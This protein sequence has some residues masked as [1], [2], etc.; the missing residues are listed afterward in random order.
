M[1]GALETFVPQAVTKGQVDYEMVGVLLN[2]GKI[3]ILLSFI[4]MTVFFLFTEKLL[5]LANQ[6]P[7]VARYAQLY[8]FVSLP[9]LLLFGLFDCLRRWLNSL[10]YSKVPLLCQMVAVPLHVVWSYVFVIH[11][12]MEYYGTGLSGAISFMLTYCLTYLYISQN[13]QLQNVDI[14][15]FNRSNYSREGF[16]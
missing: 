12:E 9:K 5:I 15:I 6:D 13:E 2:R 3:I 10:G 8:L 14:N 7:L 4:P 11:Y 16:E 1:N